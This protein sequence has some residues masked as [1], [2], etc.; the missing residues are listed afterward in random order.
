MAPARRLPPRKLLLDDDSLDSAHDRALDPY[1]SD[2]F[3]IYDFKVRR[4]VRGRSHDWTDCPFAHPGEKARRRD[5]RRFPYSGTPCPDFRRD[6]FCPRGDACN[7]AHGV[8]ESWLHPARY[9]TMP[10]KDGIQCR[11]KVCFFA[12]TP[13]QLRVLWPSSPTS[14]LLGVSRFSPPRSPSVSPPV[15]PSVGWYASEERDALKVFDDLFSALERMA[16]AER[17]SA[18]EKDGCYGPDLEWVDEL[19]M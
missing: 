9:R 3:R 19:L 1:S 7:L 11:R 6:G 10:C 8:F 18:A 15:S 16:L 5:P 13:S 12:H 2:D 4:C 17:C 14:T